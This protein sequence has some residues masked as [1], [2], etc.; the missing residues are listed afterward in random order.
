MDKGRGFPKLLAALVVAIVGAVATAA[1]A[2]FKE[3]VA[4]RAASLVMQGALDGE[5]FAE[6][7]SYDSDPTN[8]KLTRY[9]NAMTLQQLAFR[10]IGQSKADDR[11]W[12]VSGYYNPPFLALANVS[13]SGTSGL[14]SYT[15]RAVAE[16]PL[17]FLGVQI[18]VECK[19]T[20]PVPV[21][22]K[23][24]ALLVRKEQRQLVSKYQSHLDPSSCE[25]IGTLEAAAARACRSHSVQN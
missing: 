13:A 17:A 9:R 16:G 23:C 24:P 19:G 12:N 22:L 18:V 21:L 3:D 4:V 20:S 5:W 14:G 11:S 7:L 8:S 2:F 1:F 6:S 10:I 15:G 25:E